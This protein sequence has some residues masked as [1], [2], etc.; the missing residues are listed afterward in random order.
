MILLLFFGQ[1][2][3]FRRQKA[4]KKAASTGQLQSAEVDQYGK[5]SPNTEHLGDGATSG[6]DDTNPS[7][8]AL[9][10]E[11]KTVNSSQITG[12]RS[13]Y[14]TLTTSST[15]LSADHTLHSG[16]EQEPVSDETSK[17]YR[18]LGSSQLA[19]GY[20]DHFG[21]NNGLTHTKSEP[22]DII[23]ADQL[24]NSDPVYTKP[25]IDVNINHSSFHYS[26]KAQSGGNGNSSGTYMH[27]PD[28]SDAYHTSANP[29]RSESSSALNRLGF[30][31]TSADTSGVHK[32]TCSFHIFHQAS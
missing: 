15:W 26:D 7:G 18:S 6:R 11:S 20:Y 25:N 9:A 21:E 27:D 24:I 23:I 32:G 4:A 16:S 13:S 10:H 2:E 22:T 1:L 17:L 8:S 14:G 19:N 28:A 31:S 12:V 29:E 5:H 30:P 3:E